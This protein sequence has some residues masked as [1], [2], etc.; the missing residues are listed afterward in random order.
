MTVNIDD[1][2]ECNSRLGRTDTDGKERKEQPLVAV[3]EKQTVERGEI[4]VHAIE[5]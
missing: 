5:N 4:D 1:N 3:R 2:S